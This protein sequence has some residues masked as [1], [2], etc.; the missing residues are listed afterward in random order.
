MWKKGIRTIEDIIIFVAILQEAVV[1]P[2]IYVSILC[3]N[4][5]KE[6]KEADKDV[7]QD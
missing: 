1:F 3:I 6:V 4:Q 7:I 2:V 5:A